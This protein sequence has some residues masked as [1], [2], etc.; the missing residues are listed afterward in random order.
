MVKRD[1]LMSLG[2]NLQLKDKVITLTPNEWL[3]PI[4][5]DYKLLEN[6]YL[7]GRTKEKTSS[8]LIEEAFPE[9]YSTW[10]A[11]RDLNS[12]HPA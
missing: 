4:K 1:I 11:R 5:S 10:R 6:A 2:T 7:K 9:I 12:R 3:V 8:N